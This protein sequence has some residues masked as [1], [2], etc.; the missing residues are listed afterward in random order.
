MQ[1][2]PSRNPLI[3]DGR[4]YEIRVPGTH[5]GTLS[6]YFETADGL[7]NAAS[8]WDGK[9]SGLYFTMNPVNPALH[10]R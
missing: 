9:V 5:R 6:G 8:E 1:T 7:H 10:C 4:V 3:L 2:L